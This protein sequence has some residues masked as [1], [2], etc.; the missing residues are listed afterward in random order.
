MILYKMV[1]HCMVESLDEILKCDYLSNDP[2]KKKIV[3][4]TMHDGM[5][6]FF[7]VT[8]SDLIGLDSKTA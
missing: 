6:T 8:T 1:Q 3:R 4:T 7:I 2:H 5:P